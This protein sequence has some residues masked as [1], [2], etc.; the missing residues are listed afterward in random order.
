MKFPLLFIRNNLTIFFF[1][2]NINVSQ[3]HSLAA[4]GKTIYTSYVL[5]CE[6]PPTVQLENHKNCYRSIHLLLFFF[7]MA[8]SFQTVIRRFP[9]S[10][11]S[12][13]GGFEDPVQVLNRTPT[14]PP[15]TAVYKYRTFSFKPI[16]ARCSVLFVGIVRI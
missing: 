7:L 11:V 6:V 13:S 3:T 5:R 16:L 4:E 14:S 9:L 15:E 1:F 2:F 12:H 10:Y 8:K